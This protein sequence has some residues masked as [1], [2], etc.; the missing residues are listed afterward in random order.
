[1][2]RQAAAFTGC[3][4]WAPGQGL[5]GRQA[6]HPK[7]AQAASLPRARHVHE[8]RDWVNCWSSNTCIAASCLRS[9]HDVAVQDILAK[10]ECH[11]S[12]IRWKI[13]HKI[14][15]CPH[16]EVYLLCAPADGHEPLAASVPVAF[17]CDPELFSSVARFLVGSI[18]MRSYRYIILPTPTLRNVVHADISWSH[19]Q[20]RDRTRLCT[21]IPLHLTLLG[22]NEL[23]FFSAS[24]LLRSL[25]LS[26]G[27]FHTRSDVSS[28]SC[29]PLIHR[30]CTRRCAI[31]QA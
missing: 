9:P 18:S 15:S 31:A 28:R 6:R 17:C 23:L 24:R 29:S 20:Q 8:E 2:L 4:G 30:P 1:M 7:F 19:T 25:S 12:E 16:T 5:P 27:G 22:A 10:T 21:A 3:C 11:S 13:P 14:R 26:K